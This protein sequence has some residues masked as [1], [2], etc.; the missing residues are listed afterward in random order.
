MLAMEG[1]ARLHNG[2]LIPLISGHVKIA[3]KPLY[4]I[5]LKAAA[6]AKK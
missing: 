6:Q 4:L 1:A 5:A 2:V 3:T